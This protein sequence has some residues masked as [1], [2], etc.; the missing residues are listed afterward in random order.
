MRRVAV[1]V[2]AVLALAGCS[3]AKPEPKTGPP[4]LTG[5]ASPSADKALATALTCFDGGAP[6]SLTALG[7]PAVVS[8]WASWCPPCRTELPGI[9]TYADRA[10]GKVRVVGVVTQ[11]RRAAAQSIIEDKKLTFTMLDDPDRKLLTA[12]GKGA[13]PVTLF[14]TGDGRIAYVYNAPELDEAKVGELAKQYLGVS[15]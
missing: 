5:S 6:A 15:A 13:L 4:C 8:L 9:Q 7:G 14:V 11:D 1:A 3:S 10:A 12:V 2:L